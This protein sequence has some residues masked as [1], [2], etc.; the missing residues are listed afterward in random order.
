MLRGIDNDIRVT[1]DESTDIYVTYGSSLH[2]WFLGRE[3]LTP[4][5][6]VWVSSKRVRAGLTDI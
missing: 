4:A 1:S 3:V 6:E 2:T 5:K